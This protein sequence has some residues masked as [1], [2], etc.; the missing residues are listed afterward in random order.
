MH[1]RLMEFLADP[2]DQG[3]LTLHTF[4]GQNE[5]TRDGILLNEK[6]GRW[7]VIE[8]GIPT[9]FI[10][11]L[12]PDDSRFAK[13]FRGRLEALGCAKGASEEEKGADLVR[14]ESE[15][16]ARD[17]QAEDY[18][19]MWTMKLLGLAEVPAY[20]SALSD[21]LT[22][23]LLEA[24][25]GTGRLT[26]IFAEIAPEVVAVDMSRDS[27]LRNRVRHLGRTRHPVLWLHADLTNLP[28]KD[29]AFG[30]PLRGRAARDP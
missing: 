23:P 25:A 30:P 5:N 18:D 26:G 28:L 12:R 4:E 2:H 7:Y 16:R 14:I 20:K 24:G 13:R 21:N 29:G 11:P 22:T 8:D 6:T 19:R 15:R 9:L 27:L 1:Q 17:E 3:P 10:D